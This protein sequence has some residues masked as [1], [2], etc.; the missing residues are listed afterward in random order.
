M[1]YLEDL[2]P[3]IRWDDYLI[4]FQQQATSYRQYILECVVL[5][6]RLLW[7]LISHVPYHFLELSPLLFFLSG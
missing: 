7:P 2:L 6:A 3:Q 1:Q 5:L 4:T